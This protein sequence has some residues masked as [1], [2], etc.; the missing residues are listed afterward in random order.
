[1]SAERL[2]ILSGE[3]ANQRCE[4]VA[5]DEEL[6]EIRVQLGAQACAG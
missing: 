6:R 4:I 3:P 1:M 5:K 2:R